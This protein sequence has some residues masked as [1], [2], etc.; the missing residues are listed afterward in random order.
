MLFAVHLSTISP[1]FHLH[2][3]R[4][5][6]QGSHL[7]KTEKAINLLICKS[8]K[9][10]YKIMVTIAGHNTVGDGSATVSLWQL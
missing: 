9:E 1:L 4:Y 6:E 2:F 3:Q 7:N 5:I 8:D 10:L